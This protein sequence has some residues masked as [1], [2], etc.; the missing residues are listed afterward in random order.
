MAVDDRHQPTVGLFGCPRV[1]VGG[2]ANVVPRGSRRL[3]AFVA[4]HRVRLERGYVAGV[5][6]PLGDDV[7]ATA[8]LRSALWRLRCAGID[9]IATDK[10][11]VMLVP[12]TAVDV[13]TIAEWAGRL[14]S[15]Q[16]QPGDFDIGQLPADACELFP[17]WS[18]DWV[19]LER[20]RLRQRVLHALEVLARL[21]SEQGRHAEA[22]RAALRAVGVEPLR[23][24][25]QRALISSH[26]AGGSTVA[27]TCAYASFAE[28]VRRELGIEPSRRIA[29]L[30]PQPEPEVIIR[31]SEIDGSRPTSVF[32]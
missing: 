8:N 21:L 11:S 19:V 2:A 10:R 15:G 6:W 25:A 18:D 32:S 3:L 29:S 27:A 23:E 28:L 1:I 12:G 26:L 13:H 22:I 5:L 17:G 7:R 20:E 9:V 24:S 31:I 14:I 16:A 30:I 4:L